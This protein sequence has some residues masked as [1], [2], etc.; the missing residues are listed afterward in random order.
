M[1]DS[2]SQVWPHSSTHQGLFSFI[3]ITVHSSNIHPFTYLSSLLFMYPLIYLSISTYVFTII[4]CWIQQ[5]NTCI[6]LSIHPS[7]TI[8]T[9][10][11][12]SILNLLF[13]ASFPG[14]HENMDRGR[15]ESLEDIACVCLMNQ[16]GISWFEIQTK[17]EEWVTCIYSSYNH[18]ILDIM[19]M[20][21]IYI[22]TCIYI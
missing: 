10:L 7:S 2:S 22:Y 20:R 13:Y 9:F 1:Y 12:T 11:L 3:C 5:M 16:D 15:E 14:C 4:I 17:C 6:Y 19:M 21:Y 18:I 8:V